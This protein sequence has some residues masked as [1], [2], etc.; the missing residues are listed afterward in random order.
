MKTTRVIKKIDGREFFQIIR[1]YRN[2]IIIS[3]HAFDHLSIAQRE[4]FTEEDLLRPTEEKIPS[5]VGLQKNGRYIVFFKEKT[6]YLAI[7][8]AKKV[9]RLEIVTFMNKDN[10]PLI[11]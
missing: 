9:D 1:A 10:L 8:I 3:P 2:K 5:F 4:K 7:I 11:T 6:G